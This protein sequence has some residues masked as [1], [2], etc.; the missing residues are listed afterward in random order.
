MC[1]E[2]EKYGNVL[3]VRGRGGR[4]KLEE[5]ERNVRGGCGVRFL[6]KDV[7]LCTPAS[8][9]RGDAYCL[10]YGFVQTHVCTIRLPS[11]E[12]KVGRRTKMLNIVSERR[13]HMLNWCAHVHQPTVLST[14]TN[15]P[16][17]NIDV[18]SLHLRL[19]FYAN[20]TKLPKKGCVC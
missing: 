15:I 9:L 13:K 5:E 6:G 3:Y 7:E 4:R 19:L 1:D 20:A 8:H 10:Q 12:E 16:C 11:E 17:G 14:H 18:G 2:R